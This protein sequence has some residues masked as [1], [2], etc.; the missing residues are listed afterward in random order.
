[1]GKPSCKNGHELKE[2]VREGPGSNSCDGGCGRIDIRPP[3]K[4]FRCDACD[5]D[6]CS[7]CYV[8]CAPKDATSGSVRQAKMCEQGCGFICTWDANA[9]CQK[10]KASRGEKHGPK[11]DKLPKAKAANIQPATHCTKGHALADYVEPEW[12]TCDGCSKAIAAGERVMDCRPCN[13]YLCRACHGGP[14][15]EAS[16]DLVEAPA[17]TFNPTEKHKANDTS[18]S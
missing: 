11:C 12:G 18:P 10:C 17:W 14:E 7:N 16:K 3:E 6:M 2:F 5:F 9:C 4:L 8:S 1:M 13:W 15:T